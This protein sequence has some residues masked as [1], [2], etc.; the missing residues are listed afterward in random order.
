[1]ASFIEWPAFS[2]DYYN[3]ICVDFLIAPFCNARGVKRG[4]KT[5]SHQAGE[6]VLY[7]IFLKRKNMYLSGSSFVMTLDSATVTKNVVPIQQFT[8]GFQKNLIVDK[9]TSVFN[10]RH[11][12]DRSLMSDCGII[13]GDDLS[14]KGQ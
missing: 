5:L 13:S 4:L 2:K 7:R 1:M 3:Y 12:L 11:V 9:C 6:R 14:R 10:Y 8:E